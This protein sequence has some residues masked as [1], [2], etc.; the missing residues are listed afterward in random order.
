VGLEKLLTFSYNKFVERSMRFVYISFTHSTYRNSQMNNSSIKEYPVV[1]QQTVAKFFYEG[2]HSHPVRRT[3]VLIEDRPFQLIG[4]ELRE[5]H[6]IRPFES[7]PIKSYNKGQIA[8]I[9]QVDQRRKIVS[10][11]RKQGRS[12]GTSTLRR[13][14]LL[15]LAKVGV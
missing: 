4:Y 11:A 9:G 2:S 12:P 6:D 3:V 15:D 5:G 13:N 14:D 7:A 10:E 8:T 1:R